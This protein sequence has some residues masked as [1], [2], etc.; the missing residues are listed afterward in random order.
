V[1]GQTFIDYRICS[2]LDWKDAFKKTFKDIQM[3]DSDKEAIQ[4][5]KKGNKFQYEEENKDV[6][7]VKNAF[8]SHSS[9]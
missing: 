5:K 3:S 2:G 4:R 9:E 8:D 6:E 1:K 7:A